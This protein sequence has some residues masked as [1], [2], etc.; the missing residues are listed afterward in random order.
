MNLLPEFYQ[1]SSIYQSH[2]P[3]IK[4][5]GTPYVLLLL[6]Y[7]CQSDVF[8]LKYVYHQINHTGI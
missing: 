6:V 3:M 2:H 8:A 1:K 5:I 7:A 4:A